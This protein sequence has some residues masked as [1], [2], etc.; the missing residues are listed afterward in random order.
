LNA[1][2]EVFTSAVEARLMKSELGRISR[3]LQ[4]PQILDGDCDNPDLLK[5]P[6]ARILV[7]DNDALFERYMR[8]HHFEVIAKEVGV[9]M[10]EENTVIEKWPMRLKKGATKEEF[11]IL[12]GS[13]HVGTE[14]YVECKSLA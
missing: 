8:M 13:G 6:E 4:A 11:D 14:R 1:I 10:K 12:N 7:R 9:E 5:Y 2:Y 3:Y